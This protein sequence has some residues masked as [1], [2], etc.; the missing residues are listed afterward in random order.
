MRVLVILWSHSFVLGT[1][2]SSEQLSILLRPK[3]NNVAVSLVRRM[4]NYTFK[5]KEIIRWLRGSPIQLEGNQS[6]VKSVM[7][8]LSN[9]V[10]AKHFWC[11]Q[12][13]FIWIASSH[14]NIVSFFRL[15]VSHWHCCSKERSWFSWQGPCRTSLQVNDTSSFFPVNVKTWAGL[16]LLAQQPS[17][18]DVCLSMWIKQ[19]CLKWCHSEFI[20]LIE[21]NGVFPLHS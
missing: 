2:K 8:D 3:W 11:R 4:L 9:Q 14:L 10:H 1:R 5:R 20:S 7:L 16:L 19:W 15:P 13:I 21:K 18:K 6:W 12:R 17:R